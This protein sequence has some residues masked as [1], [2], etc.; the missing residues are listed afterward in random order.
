MY[1]RGQRIADIQRWPR[2]TS[3]NRELSC[4]RADQSCPN[5]LENPVLT[6]IAQK[7][8]QS[9]AQISIRYILQRGAVA[10]VK[11]FNPKRMKQNL[12]V[13]D[14]CLTPED[15]KAIDGLNRNVRYWKLAM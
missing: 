13:Y 3:S 5:L 14:F 4:P 11:S 1:T 2:C 15:M 9:P 8:K 10:I 6:S 7:Y 12:Q